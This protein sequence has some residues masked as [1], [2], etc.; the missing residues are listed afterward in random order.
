MKI[1]IISNEIPGKNISGGGNYLWSVVDILLKKKYSLSFFLATSYLSGVKTR[2]YVSKLNKK[3]NFKVL[4]LKSLNKNL[5]SRVFG[6]QTFILKKLIEEMIENNKP[7][8]LFLYGSASIIWTKK[9]NFRKKFCPIVEMPG[10]INKIRFKYRSTNLITFFKNF[11]YLILSYLLQKE[12]IKYLKGIPVIGHSSEEYRQILLKNDLKVKYYNHPNIFEN[13][14]FK[15][16]LTIR[17]KISDK[18]FN[19]LMLGKMSTINYAQYKY[20]NDEIIDLIKERLNTNQIK[21]NLVGAEKFNEF[22]KLYANTFVYHKKFVKNVESVFF[23]NDI[24]LSPSPCSAG[25]RSRLHQAFNY[26]CVV[27]CTKFDALSDPYLKHNYNCLISANSYE[28]VENILQLMKN[29]KKYNY[30]QQNA[31]KTFKK[32]F[33]NTK[34]V[35]EYLSDIKKIK[36]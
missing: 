2:L 36:N 33:N 13:Y 29:K 25:L 21:I 19:I 3:I 9:I 18:F 22:N 11:L 4:D 15:A 12:I 23:K 5:F 1:L 7:D 14:N 32:E 17:K 34:I 16:L 26:G 31:F 10:E 30:L 28:I 6:H 27:L 35:N 8:V 20:L 24:I